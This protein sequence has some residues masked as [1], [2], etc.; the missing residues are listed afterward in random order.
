MKSFLYIALLYLT[1]SLL[2]VGCSENT[3]EPACIKAEVI[4]TDCEKGW[5]IL[6]LSDD[7]ASI[8]KKGHS[9]IGQ[10]QGGFVT[11]DNL[12]ESHRQVGNKLEVALDLNGDYGPRCVAVNVMYPAVRVKRVCNS[13]DVTIR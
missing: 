3:P 13:P 6:K 11:T 7:K 9:Y 12:P 5:Y 2:V 8:E 1:L 10:L 4:G